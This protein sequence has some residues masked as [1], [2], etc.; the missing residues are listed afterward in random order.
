MKDGD[1]VVLWQSGLEAGAYAVGRLVGPPY[2]KNGEW[3]V[4]I[5]YECHGARKTSH[6]GARQN[7][8]L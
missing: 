8:P 3:R 4:D 5:Q 1:G 6:S 2:K 7:Q